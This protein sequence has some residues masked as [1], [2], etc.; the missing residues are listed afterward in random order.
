[1]TMNRKNQLPE[2]SESE[3]QKHST[4]QGPGVGRSRVSEEVQEGGG[5]MLDKDRETF[6]T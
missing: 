4:C 3:Q 1:M 6:L 2:K 5:R